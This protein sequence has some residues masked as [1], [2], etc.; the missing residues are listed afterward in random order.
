MQT[1]R[2]VQDGRYFYDDATGYLLYRASIKVKDFDMTAAKIARKEFEEFANKQ[3]WAI[4]YA[5]V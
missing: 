1:L 5:E 2:V 3:D 4:F